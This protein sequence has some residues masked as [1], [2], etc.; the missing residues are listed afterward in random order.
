VKQIGS[1]ATSGRAA[2]NGNLQAFS[3]LNLTRQQRYYRA[4]A[5]R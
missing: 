1:A 2:P 4:G 3:D 5:L